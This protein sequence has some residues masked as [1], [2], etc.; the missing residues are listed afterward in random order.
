VPHSTPP[1]R[2]LRKG[3]T[4]VPR[5]P[6]TRGSASGCSRASA[7]IPGRSTGSPNPWHP[8]IFRRALV[9]LS[10][11]RPICVPG[12][13]AF[14]RPRRARGFRR[15][16]PGS[17]EPTSPPLH[18]PIASSCSPAVPTLGDWLRLRRPETKPSAVTFFSVLA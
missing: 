7:E 9:E 8:K 3:R 17:I 1:T 18:R 13:Q 16:G 6:R 2:A 12:P 4:W 14:R 11:E 5:V 10:E 15:V